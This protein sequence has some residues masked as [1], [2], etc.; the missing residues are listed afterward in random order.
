MISHSLADTEHVEDAEHSPED[1]E[2]FQTD[3]EEFQTDT[4]A[5]I[6]EDEEDKTS[7]KHVTS[8]G[9]L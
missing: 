2:E 8:K 6:R 7:P 5:I 1:V 4:D 3:T 9:R